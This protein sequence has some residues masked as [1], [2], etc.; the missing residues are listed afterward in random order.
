MWDANAI[1]YVVRYC[2]DCGH[3]NPPITQWTDDLVNRCPECNSTMVSGMRF[4][5]DGKV[6]INGEEKVGQGDGGI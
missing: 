6:I 4:V 2:R 5:P 1:D 3:A